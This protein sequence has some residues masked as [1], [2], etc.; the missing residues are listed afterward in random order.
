VHQQPFRL[1]NV[2]KA[3]PVAEEAV[4]SGPRARP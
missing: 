2:E 1:P 4:P 3:K